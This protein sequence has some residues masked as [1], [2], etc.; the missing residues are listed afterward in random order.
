MASTRPLIVIEESDDERRMVAP[1]LAIRFRW[2]G[3]RWAHDLE[4][5]TEVQR[6]R[7]A[8]SF[9]ESPDQGD[10]IRVV[11]P[12][13]Q[14][15]Q[16]RQ[17]GDNAQALLVGRSGPHHYSAVVHL[18]VG[19]DGSCA[20]FEV[21]DRCRSEVQA[22]A[23]TYV[24]DPVIGERAND[25]DDHPDVNVIWQ[26]PLGEVRYV[27]LSV[28]GPAWTARIQL[29]PARPP[30]YLRAQAEARLIPGAATQVY[31]YRWAA[32]RDTTNSRH[33]LPCGSGA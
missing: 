33:S 19:A 4:I 6:V 16:V 5:G 29:A 18:R 21:A 12:T 10:P 11:S 30:A 27:R 7:L 31:R 23:S 9:E 25:D 22:L 20:E 28:P 15:L 3:D 1:T 26:C 32:L 13:Y 17:D 8:R 24:I 2:T 14:E